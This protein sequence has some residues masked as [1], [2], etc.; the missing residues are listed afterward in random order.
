M[1]GDLVV[2]AVLHHWYRICRRYELLSRS[3]VMN[4]D[5]ASVCH[6][7]L[8]HRRILRQFRFS[9]PQ[10]APVVELIPIGPLVANTAC[11]SRP[12]D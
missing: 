11:S 12:E 2:R 7:G 3:E 10:Q 6:Y 4:A 1:F 8:Y 9:P 5:G